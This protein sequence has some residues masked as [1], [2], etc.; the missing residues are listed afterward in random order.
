[1]ASIH[2][3]L[4]QIS[5]AVSVWYFGG[6]KRSQPAKLPSAAS[7]RSDLIPTHASRAV[8]ANLAQIRIATESAMDTRIFV[9]AGRSFAR[10]PRP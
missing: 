8:M 5:S 10:V 9:T 3:V 1:M 6:L 4:L 2:R 7:P